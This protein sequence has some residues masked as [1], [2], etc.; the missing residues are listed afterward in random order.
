M[1]HNPKVGGSKPLFTQFLS[2]VL[3]MTLVSVKTLWGKW[4][5]KLLVSPQFMSQSVLAKVNGCYQTLSLY[6]EVRIEA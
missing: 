5:F 4:P 2:V 6:C 3:P 1:A